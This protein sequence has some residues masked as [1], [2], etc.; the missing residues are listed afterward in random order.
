[1]GLGQSVTENYIVRSKAVDMEST[2]GGT[3]AGESEGPALRTFFLNEC[4]FIFG[5]LL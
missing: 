2:L 3:S 5:C 1:M 4:I